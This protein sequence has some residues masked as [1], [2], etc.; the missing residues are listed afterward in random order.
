MLSPDGHQLFDTMPSIPF[1]V[2][3][4]HSTAVQYSIIVHS[5][6][7]VI[8]SHIA[9]VAAAGHPVYIEGIR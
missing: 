2:H 9:V 4:A 5:T 8:L 7:M 3:I 1:R 6:M